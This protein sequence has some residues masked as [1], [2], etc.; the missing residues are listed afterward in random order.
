M[1]KIKSIFQYNIGMS[2]AE[3]SVGSFLIWVALII[4]LSFLLRFVR[5]I[6][7]RKLSFERKGKFKPVFSFFNYS[8]Y[9]VVV[10]LM[11]QNAGV[12]LTALL[13][14]S[15]ALLVG[16][17]FALQTFFQDIISGIFILVDQTV[18][19]GDIIQLDDKVG[20][21]ENITLRTTRAVTV[22]NKVLIIPNH[23]YLTTTL[24]N[25]TENEEQT[26]ESVSVGVAYGTDLDELKTL[27]IDIALHHK[28]VLKTPPPILL[29][30]NF[31]DS[32]LDFELVFTL[33]DGF[34]SEMV[35]SDIRYAIDKSLRERNIEIPFPQRV[36]HKAD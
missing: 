33:K 4:T 21:V 12:N 19:V 1:E 13:A 24:F 27:M 18:H 35:K 25:W 23:M 16:V 26:R 14:A 7:T 2:D 17:G 15:A 11:L 29:F 36:I 31:G 10:L 6:L 20:R 32:S 22:D 34:K 8:L 3:M 5:R 28:E 9:T 30:K